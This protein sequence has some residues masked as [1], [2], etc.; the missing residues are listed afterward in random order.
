METAMTGV[1][2]LEP[3]QRLP[4]DSGGYVALDPTG[5]YVAFD[6]AAQ[7]C[8]RSPNIKRAI[9]LAEGDDSRRIRMADL[10]AQRAAIEERLEALRLAPTPE[11]ASLIRQADQAV[12]TYREQTAALEAQLAEIDGVIG[13]RARD[14][15]AAAEQQREQ[16]LAASRAQ[17]LASA[18][19]ELAAVERAQGHLREFVSTLNVVFASHLR[20]RE[21]AAQI[22]QG[23]RLPSGF[24]VV[25]LI[26]RL[27]GSLAAEL[28]RV[29]TPGALPGAAMRIG[30]LQLPNSSLYQTQQSWRQA[31]ERIL[32]PAVRE[33]TDDSSNIENG[34]AN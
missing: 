18:E 17:L 32:M 29:R 34:K 25:D 27:G 24:S 31:L 23:G 15:R 3:G 21:L 30:P 14:Q 22:T 33:L 5:L 13:Q 4:V 26:A 9:A 10:V 16:Q 8:G 28:S 12:A 7:E 2:V 1:V 20:T 6:A 11:V 19:A